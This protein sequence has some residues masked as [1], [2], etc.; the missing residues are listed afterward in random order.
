MDQLIM[1]S[2]IFLFI[3]ITCLLDIVP[4]LEGEIQSWSLMEVKGLS[5]KQKELRITRSCTFE[6]KTITMQSFGRGYARSRPSVGNTERSSKRRD[7]IGRVKKS[8]AWV[9]SGRVGYL[10][11]PT[12]KLGF[13]ELIKEK[14]LIDYPTDLHFFS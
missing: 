3:L 4:I 5:S 6:F 7:S 2:L 12:A 1:P 9:G 8:E 11:D 10:K 14:L 13:G